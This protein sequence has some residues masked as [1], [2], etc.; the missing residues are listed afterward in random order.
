MLDFLTPTY[1]FKSIHELPISFYK[2]NGIKGVLFDV[3]NTLEPYATRLPGEKTVA[4]FELLKEHGIKIAVI[5]NNHKERV[6][7]FCE[8][9][10]VEYSYDSAKPSK[11]K[12]LEAIDRL[13]LS[14]DEVVMVGDQLFTDIWGASNSNIRSI[15]VDR[16]NNNEILFIRIKRFLEQPL[17]NR[18][19]K[20]GYGRI[21]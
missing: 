18:I 10:Q 17:L 20:K 3:D 9:L 4:L 16:I 12:I 7:A 8:P 11:K 5:S 15:F 1:Y 2:E 13:G 21:K 19:T 6:S 14:C